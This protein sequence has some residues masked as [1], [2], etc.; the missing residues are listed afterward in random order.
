MN[1]TLYQASLEN[2]IN[3]SPEN[4]FMDKIIQ[5]N[6]ILLRNLS[7]L[8][9]ILKNFMD[10][11]SIINNSIKVISKSLNIYCSSNLIPN[12]TFTKTKNQDKKTE[13]ANKVN[14]NSNTNP[15]NSSIANILQDYKEKYLNIGNINE[16]DVHGKDRMNKTLRILKVSV[17]LF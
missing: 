5:N 10:F 4:L 7:T 14:N 17:K 1:P 9:E 3:I 12:L 2:I 8:C 13:G 15:N 11:S 6:E 16:T